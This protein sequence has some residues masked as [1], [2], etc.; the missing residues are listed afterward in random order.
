[1]QIGFRL[2][3]SI[4]VS[5]LTKPDGNGES[6]SLGLKPF[7]RFKQ[8]SPAYSALQNSEIS[9]ALQ[10]FSAI[11]ISQT[12]SINNS[13][14]SSLFIHTTGYSLQAMQPARQ[15]RQCSSVY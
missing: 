7:T 3:Q 12:G 13:Y 6:I 10:V 9:C 15:Q 2:G 4:S 5:H 8:R 11:C 1:S 14:N